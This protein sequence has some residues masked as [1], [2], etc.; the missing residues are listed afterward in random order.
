MS[1]KILRKTDLFDDKKGG[2]SQARDHEQQ[3]QGRVEDGVNWGRVGSVTHFSEKVH[4]V[5]FIKKILSDTVVA[6][7][8]ESMISTVGVSSKKYQDSV[9]RVLFDK[10]K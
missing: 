10:S 3:C 7:D 4:F 5:A 1:K 8:K 2:S 9:F 6:L